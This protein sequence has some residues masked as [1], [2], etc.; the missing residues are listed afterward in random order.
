MATVQLS[1]IID[2]TVFQDLPAVN[3]PE[4]TAFYESGII[5]MSDLLTSLANAAGDTAE[6]PFWQDLDPDDAPNLSNDDPSDEASPKKIAQGKQVARKAFLNNGW[7]ESDLASELVLGPKA[8]DQIRA[9]IDT[10]WLRQWQRRLIASCKGIVADNIA[11]SGGDMVH[12]AAGATNADVTTSTVFTRQN[13]TSAAF[14]MGDAVDGVVAI[15]VHSVIMKRMVDNDEIDYIPDSQGNL[16]IPTYLGRRI[17]MDDSLP[18][19]PAAGAAGGDAAAQYTSVLYGAGAFGYANGNPKMPVE[20]ERKAAQGKGAGIET[21]WSRK[22][23]LI[24]PAGYKVDTAP[25]D[26]SYSLAELATAGTW[27][28]VVERK[29]V[30]LAFLITNG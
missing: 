29:N 4:K 8:M 30:P 3:S 14:T 28:R 11:N 26:E 25:T 22:T 24:H 1:D 16:T 7:S 15:G 12:V 9:R 17:F 21:I 5:V 2:V 10:Y 27:S 18:F 13:F 19:V 20:I 6:L 23:W